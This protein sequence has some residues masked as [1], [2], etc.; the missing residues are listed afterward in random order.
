M[1]SYEGI[2][3]EGKTAALI[4]SLE[5]VQLPIVNDEI[6]CTFKYHPKENEI[7]DDLVGKE[8]EVLLIGYGYD[9]NNSG[10]Q[11]QLPSEIMQYYINYDEDNPQKLKVPHIT[12]SLSIGAKACQ[13]KDLYFEPLPKPIAI[14]GRFGYWIKDNGNEYV[15]YEPYNSTKKSG[16]I[17]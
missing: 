3:F 4:H 13:T 16:I 1:L 11:L 7:F 2:F 12:A 5:A 14:I 6:H 8:I 17:K 9:K 15:S 10:F